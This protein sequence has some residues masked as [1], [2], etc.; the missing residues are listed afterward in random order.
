MT[1]ELYLTL[2]LGAKLNKELCTFTYRNNFDWE[3]KHKRK[4]ETIDIKPLINFSD[5]AL[6][7]KK[8][9]TNTIYPTYLFSEEEPE[10]RQKVYKMIVENNEIVNIVKIPRP[11]I[12]SEK[13]IGVNFAESCTHGQ[14][15]EQVAKSNGAISSS[16]LER[17]EQRR[18]EQKEN[19]YTKGRGAV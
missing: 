7:Q 19:R 2:P 9:G 17:E 10:T 14:R 6:L 5:V 1:K 15:W 11:P 4:S 16:A 13:K 12:V 8:Y 3:L 18:Q